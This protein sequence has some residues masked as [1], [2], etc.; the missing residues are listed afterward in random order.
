[1]QNPFLI[2][3]LV[4]LRPLERLDAAILLP[5]INDQEVTR[6]LRVH[7]PL[8]LTAEEDFINHLCTQSDTVALGIALRADDRLVGMCSLNQIDSKNRHA[9]FGIIIGDKNAWGKGHGTEATR[10]IVDYGFATLNL[11]RIWLH[12]YEYNPRAIHTYEKL[13]FRYEGVLRQENFREGRYWDTHV[14][15][16]LREEWKP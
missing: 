1:M 4:Y 8:N 13:G 10:L 16:V 3:T 7:R 9:Q 14:M 12:V 5:W 6:T 15:A 11:H 2:G